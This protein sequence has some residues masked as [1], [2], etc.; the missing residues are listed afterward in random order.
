MTPRPARR[1]PGARDRHVASGERGERRAPGPVAPITLG[2]EQVEGRRAVHELLTARTRPVHGVFV[3]SAAVG[4]D[5]IAALAG[6]HLRVVAPE[7]LAVLAR[8]DAHQGVVA[9]A[10][11]LRAHDLASLLRV[12]RALVVMLDGVTDPHNVGAILRTAETAG[13]TG[14]VLPR[15]RGAHLTPTVAKAA[16]G[17]I[18]HLPI[19]LV[20]GIP[21]ALDR[22]RREQVWTVGLDAG[23]ET[24][25]A[26]LA[27][28]GEPL[29]LVVGAEG[30]GLSRLA[31]ERCDATV[32]IALHGR[33]ASL[34]VAAAAAIALHHVAAVRDREA[35]Q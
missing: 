23:G 9:H 34:N 6:A 8:T 1:G 25:L 4:V 20:A 22:A 31:R 35:R 2:G 10:A 14:V 18:E 12:P 21:A 29:V 3:S 19:A 33:V 15:R 32:R 5:Q 13:A 27:L 17:A 11:P 16:A 26:D 7:R 28:A 30:R 24:E